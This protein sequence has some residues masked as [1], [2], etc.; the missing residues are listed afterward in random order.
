MHG[1]PPVVSHS[2]P[3]HRLRCRCAS[4][5]TSGM[6][7][8]RAAAQRP[9]TAVCC[10]A[11]GQLLCGAGLPDEP[12]AFRRRVQGAALPP[13][14]AALSHLLCHCH[15]N[16]TLHAA[17]TRRHPWQR[18]SWQPGSQWT[19]WAVAT[20]TLEPPPAHQVHV[21]FSGCHGPACGGKDTQLAMQCC[22][23]ST[24]TYGPC[25]PELV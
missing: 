9:L 15:G 21:S 25:V 6:R 7:A 12:V 11:D 13:L 20:P 17:V 22:S 5:G 23:S 1:R 24:A 4:R 14:C 18:I 10:R 2:M 16:D 19:Y 8:R 3:Q